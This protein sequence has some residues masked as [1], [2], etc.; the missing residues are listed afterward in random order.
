MCVDGLILLLAIY[1]ISKILSQNTQLA[2]IQVLT[3]KNI[4]SWAA[5]TQN[6]LHEL[7]IKIAF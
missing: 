4:H 7:L 6:R 2:I 1:F 3:S 5:A